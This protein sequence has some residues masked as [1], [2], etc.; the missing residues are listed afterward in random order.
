MYTARHVERLMFIRHCR[1][2]DMTLDEIRGL[3]RFIDAPGKNCAEVNDLLDQHIEHVGERIEELRSLDQQL[4]KLRRMCTRIG[5][6]K[7][8]GILQGLADS[9]R[10]HGKESRHSNHSH[11]RG[12]HR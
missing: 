7:D 9:G 2:L 11:V 8:C 5:S 12:T 10:N 6:G 3:L 4:R 1:C